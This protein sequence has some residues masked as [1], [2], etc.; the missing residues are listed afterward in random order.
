MHVLD[1]RGKTISQQRNKSLGQRIHLTPR[2][3]SVESI[4]WVKYFAESVHKIIRIL[5]EDLETFN[6]RYI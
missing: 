5:T 2:Y 1:P 4:I 3:D 6:Y